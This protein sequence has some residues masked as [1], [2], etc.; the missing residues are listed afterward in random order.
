MKKAF[1]LTTIYFLLSTP[2]LAQSVDLIWQAETYT[3]PFYQGRAMWSRQSIISFLAI[4]QELPNP[5]N[6]IYNW[7]RN[8]TI[9]GLVSGIGKDT[10]SFM[11]TI[12]SKPQTIRIEVL[13]L[14]EELLAEKTITITPS[15][16]RIL[17]YENNPLYGFIFNNELSDGFRLREQEAT[18]TA[19]P[20]FFST[21]AR[22]YLSLKYEWNSSNSP[23]G[24][25][26]SVTYRA[27][28][29]A[30]GL[31]SVSLNISSNDFLQQS[32]KKSLLIKFGEQ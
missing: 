17:V 29:D 19:F 7:T 2:A 20:L 10:L 4:T 13:S 11:D 18:L 9:L 16:P 22:E 30:S 1:L 23:S 24:N 8:G 28:E 14:E 6:L 3:P 15:D 12:F 31:A 32:A 5:S 26:S 25:R 27:P 21:P